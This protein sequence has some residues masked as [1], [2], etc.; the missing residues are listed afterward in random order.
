MKKVF[1]FSLMILVMTS[2]INISAQEKFIATDSNANSLPMSI[3]KN[4]T[5]YYSRSIYNIDVY[6]T[7]YNPFPT[8]FYYDDGTYRGQLPIKSWYISPTD[9]VVTYSG[10]I[11][12]FAP[13]SIM[14]VE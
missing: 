10:L 14:E 11:G 1:I 13:A 7:K 5:K 12:P 2:T 9:Y 4:I 6:S 8:V 3:R